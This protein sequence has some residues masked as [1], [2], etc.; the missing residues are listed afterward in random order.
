METNEET[1]AIALITDLTERKQ[2]SEAI[3]DSQAQLA[4]AREIAELGLWDW[5]IRTGEIRCSEEWG[6][7]H[8]LAPGTKSISLDEGLKLIHTDDRERILN[9]FNQARRGVQP[10]A[11]EFRVVWPDGT[12]CWFMGTG[13]VVSDLEGNP[14]RVLGAIMDITTIKLAEHDRRA[15]A[16]RLAAAQADERRRISQELHDDLTQRLAGV[17]MDLGRLAANPSASSRG[18]KEC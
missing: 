12:I 11:T 1:P 16:S 13:R 3:R 4:V 17:A 5:D 9:N 8:G 2:A 18:L 14:L 7:L 6:P 10:C 15:E